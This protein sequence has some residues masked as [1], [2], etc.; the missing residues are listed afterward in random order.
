MVNAGLI[1]EGGG[2]RGIYTAGVLDCLLEHGIYFENIYGVSAGACHACSY[3]SRQ[4]GRGAHTVIDFIG[5]RHYAGFYSFVT[6]GDF[7]GEKMSYHE[8]PDTLLP[9]DYPAFRAKE[10]SLLAVVT[11][12]RSGAAEYLPV[13][14]LKKDM[15]IIR[16]SS[17]LP[18]LSNLVKL[19]NAYYLDGGITDSI[20][21]RKSIR[22]GNRKNLVVLT[23]HRGYIKNPNKMLPMVRR[24][25]RAFPNLVHAVANRHNNYN[26]SLSLTYREEAEC[27]AFV[28]Q[29]KEPVN[30]SRLEKNKTKLKQLYRQGYRDAENQIDAL[31]AFLGH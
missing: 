25:Y 2:M 3:L 24:K 14:D 31:M 27:R 10:E 30:I 11:N 17:S 13:S 29:P 22:D 7:F 16:A 5:D 18:L 6:S 1:L 19:G 15:D 21:L 23:Q 8:I 12:C 20:P 9:F 28:I 4:K 26:Y